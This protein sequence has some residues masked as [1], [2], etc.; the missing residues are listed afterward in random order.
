M[1]PMKA[2]KSALW[3]C[4]ERVILVRVCSRGKDETELRT[5]VFQIFAIAKS[6]VA[7]NIQNNQRKRRKN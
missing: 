5:A 7:D 1:D 3:D 4:R 6:V 2:F